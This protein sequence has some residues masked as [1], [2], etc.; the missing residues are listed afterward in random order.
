MVKVETCF[1]FT[2]RFGGISIGRRHA[3]RRTR[4]VVVFLRAAST[5]AC[6]GSRSG[7][8]VLQASDLSA[9]CGDFQDFVECDGFYRTRELQSIFLAKAFE[10]EP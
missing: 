8:V 6:S 10:P 3:R 4:R 1:S 5:G 9:N 2:P 7:H